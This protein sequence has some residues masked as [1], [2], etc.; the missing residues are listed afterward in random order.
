VP[1]RLGRSWGSKN[2]PPKRMRNCSAWVRRAKQKRS[3][4]GRRGG[5]SACAG[6][7]TAARK[8]N[9][10]SGSCGHGTGSPAARYGVATA[11]PCRF[12]EFAFTLDPG[13]SGMVAARARRYLPRT[14]EGH[15]FTERRA[16]SG[17][18]SRRMRTK[19]ESAS[20]GDEAPARHRGSVALLDAAGRDRWLK[21]NAG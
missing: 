10:S 6:T 2:S 21:T 11:N 4:L 12:V 7:A 3:C 19:S 18:H 1:G 5:V 14:R 9:G 13:A 8:R 15:A 17:L 20:R 16:A